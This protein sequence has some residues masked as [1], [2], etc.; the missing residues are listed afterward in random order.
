MR[1]SLGVDYTYTSAQ[2]QQMVFDALASD[3]AKTIEATK[4]LLER[5]NQRGCPLN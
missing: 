5:A 3:D 4:D 1:V 2:V